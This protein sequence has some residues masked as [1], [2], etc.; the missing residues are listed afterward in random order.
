ML[1]PYMLYFILGP[2]CMIIEVVGEVLM[3]LYLAE[4]I[5]GGIDGT[6]TTEGSL[7]A[8]AKMIGTALIMMVGGVG[9]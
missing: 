6:L 4:V 5:T 9:G 3:P 8:M 2:L 1:K 7:W